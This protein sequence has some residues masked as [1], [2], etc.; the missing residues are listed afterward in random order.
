MAPRILL[1]LVFSH[2][3]LMFVKRAAKDMA[4]VIL[5]D[6]INVFFI[7]RIESGFES[8]LSRIADGSRRQASPEVSVVGRI[9]FQ[10]SLQKASCVGSLLFHGVDYSWITIKFHPYSQT[11]M[12]YG[13]D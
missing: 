7:R 11:V 8:G 9:E 3:P 13:R 6:E 4:S 10:M 5:G 1:S 12:E 2:R